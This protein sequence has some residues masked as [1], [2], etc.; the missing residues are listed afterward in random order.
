MKRKE[1]P[2]L[3]IRSI[4][5]DKFPIKQTAGTEIRLKQTN[6][7]ISIS[8]PVTSTALTFNKLQEFSMPTTKPSRSI[9]K[10]S[11]YAKSSSVHYRT[12]LKRFSTAWLPFIDSLDI[13]Y[14]TTRWWY[15]TMNY[16][17]LW[18][19]W[20]CFTYSFIDAIKIRV[21]ATT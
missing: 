16:K 21:L 10:P 5:F 6:Y 9:S 13:V 4:I 2:F 14:D 1:S 17:I 11:Q 15:C 19:T 7:K 18:P 3:R 20:T 12:E 8:I